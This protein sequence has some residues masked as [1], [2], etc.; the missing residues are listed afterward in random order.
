MLGSPRGHW[1]EEMD[2]REGP[3]GNLSPGSIVIDI[4]GNVGAGVVRMPEALAGHE[5][6]IRRTEEVWSGIHTGIR[7]GDALGCFAV[8][9]GLKAGTY[10]IRIKGTDGPPQDL[11]IEGGEVTEVMWQEVSRQR[12]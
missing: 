1:A 4:G 7:S 2:E 3:P 12:N 11:C 6:E 10:E 9:G 5:V 8:F